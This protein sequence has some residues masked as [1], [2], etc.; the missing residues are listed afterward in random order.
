[1]IAHRLGISEPHR[2]RIAGDPAR[3]RYVMTF[4]FTVRRSIPS[5]RAVSS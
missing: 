2:S 1:L 5:R 4:A 3:A